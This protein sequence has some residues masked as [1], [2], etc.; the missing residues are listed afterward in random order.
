MGRRENLHVMLEIQLGKQRWVYGAWLFQS[1]S[2]RLKHT[3]FNI[4]QST[5]IFESVKKGPTKKQVPIIRKTHSSL[6]HC[7]STRSR[8]HIPMGYHINFAIN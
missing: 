3:N 1:Y 5:E 6:L 7:H 8:C 2:L 4:Y